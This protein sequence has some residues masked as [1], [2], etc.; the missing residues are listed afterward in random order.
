LLVF[1][2]DRT[3]TRVMTTSN[4]GSPRSL[5]CARC[6]AV[7]ECGLNANCWCAA[8]LYRLPMTKAWIEDCICPA[9]LRK[10]AEALAEKAGSRL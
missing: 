10:A 6:G 1:A 4:A 5:S 2:A 8:E 7:F 3:Q 9:C